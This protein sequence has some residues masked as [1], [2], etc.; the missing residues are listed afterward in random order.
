MPES[1]FPHQHD[2]LAAAFTKCPCPGPGA[3]QTPPLSPE[4]K[5][6][7][8]K[9]KQKMRRDR[10]KKC[11]TV[12]QNLNKKCEVVGQKRARWPSKKIQAD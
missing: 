2:K 9:V 4:A 11:R 7:R 1:A 6:V 12:E 3:S 5:V 8:A 10:A